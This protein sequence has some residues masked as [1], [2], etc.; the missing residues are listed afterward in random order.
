MTVNYFEGNMLNI[1]YSFDAAIKVNIYKDLF[2]NF[3]DITKLL[4]I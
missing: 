2:M 1:Q 4:D 3:S